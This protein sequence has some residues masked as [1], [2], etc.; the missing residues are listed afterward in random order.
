MPGYMKPQYY[1][2]IPVDGTRRVAVSKEV[3]TTRN[4]FD[5][6][7]LLNLS[8]EAKS[9]LHVGSGMKSIERVGRRL[10]PI[11]EALRDSSGMP[12]IPGSTLKGVMSTNYLAL[13]GSI[14]EVSECFGTSQARSNCYGPLVSKLFFS[15]AVPE[16]EVKPIYREVRMAWQPNIRRSRH[17]KIYTSKAPQTAPYGK[18]ECI[19]RGTRLKTSIVGI[20]LRD[21][22]LGGILMALGLAYV[23]GKVEARPLKVGYGKPQGF[24]SLQ[25]D[26]DRS[27]L[28]ER[29]IALLTLRGVETSKLSSPDCA[30]LIKVFAEEGGR[31]G[32]DVSNIWRKI[33]KT[34]D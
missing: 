10:L 29:E 18:M 28:D 11:L 25:V 2:F 6:I 23:G 3:F 22:E 30:E 1:E 12:Y 20:N 21:Y 4:R 27:T 32:R 34:L 7:A 8:L 19:P 26:P 9:E 16:S 31:R 15:N 33:F 13:S 17:V 14:E 5:H 24:G